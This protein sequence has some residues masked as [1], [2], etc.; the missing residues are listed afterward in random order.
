MAIPACRHADGTISSSDVSDVRRMVSE[1]SDQL[2]P[3]FLAV[4]RLDDLEEVCQASRG[5]VPTFLDQLHTSRELLEVGRLRG[6][7]WVLAEEWDGHFQQVTAPSHDVTMQVLFVVVMARVDQHL[8]N[9]KE[10]VECPQHGDAL[11]TLRY[12]K[13][14]RH[15]ISGFVALSAIAVR[16]PNQADGEASFPVYKPRDPTDQS[17]LLV[18]CTQRIVTFAVAHTHAEP[19]WRN[20]IVPEVRHGATVA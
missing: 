2:I 3:G 7:Q 5:L 4:H 17:F 12:G 11:S 8:P 9:P 18:V 6:T 15:L 14:M 16:L 19:S 20:S 13:L 10:F 1:D